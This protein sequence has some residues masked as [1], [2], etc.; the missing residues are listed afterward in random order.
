[1]ATLNDQSIIDIDAALAAS[2]ARKEAKQAKQASETGTDTAPIEAAKRRIKTPDER[3]ADLAEIERQRKERKDKRETERTEKAQKAA[4][5]KGPAHM[6]KVEKAAE[7]LGALSERAQAIFDATIGLSAAERTAL[8]AYLQHHNRVE[9]TSASLQAKLEAGQRVKITGGS[10]PRLIGKE[11]TL[12]KVSR[13][14][15]YVE[16]E[17]QPKPAYLFTSDVERVAA[18]EA[19]PASQAA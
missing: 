12:A 8:A 11:G 16:I 4:D 18:P 17:G 13:I 7:R 1:M 19:P 14:R 2:K 10:D 3:A 9:A 6:K 5:A 15:C